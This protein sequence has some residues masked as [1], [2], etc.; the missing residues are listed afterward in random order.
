M[1]VKDRTQPILLACNGGHLLVLSDVI[2]LIEE[3][4]RINERR[5]HFQVDPQVWVKVEESV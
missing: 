1:H 2:N 3:P 5:D 4:K